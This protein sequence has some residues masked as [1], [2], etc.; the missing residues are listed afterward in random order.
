MKCTGNTTH[1]MRIGGMKRDTTIYPI[2]VILN[3]LYTLPIY[4]I[5]KAQD[6]RDPIFGHVKISS[7]IEYRPKFNESN[8][9]KVGL[10][11]NHQ[12]INFTNIYRREYQIQQFRKL[13][14]DEKV[15][16]EYFSGKFQSFTYK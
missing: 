10:I 11:H 16:Q 4:R 5:F 1:E 2:I 13:G 14:V 6:I 12:Y 7:S 8:E 15:I 3:G 9:Y